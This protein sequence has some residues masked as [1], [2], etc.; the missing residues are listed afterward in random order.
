MEKSKNL[1]EILKSV[2]SDK[3][4]SGKFKSGYYYMT[5]IAHDTIMG[6]TTLGALYLEQPM[7][8]Y[9]GIWSGLV[10]L[11]TIATGRKGRLP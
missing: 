7:A 8:S 5:N 10:Q 2:G 9:L 11:A 1:D 4:I 6:L 3:P